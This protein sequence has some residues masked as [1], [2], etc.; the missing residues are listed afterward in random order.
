MGS[1]F[2]MSAFADLSPHPRDEQLE[3]TRIHDADPYDKKVNLTVEEYQDKNG[4]PWVL[5]V[6]RQV[7]INLKSRTNKRTDQNLQTE[8]ELIMDSSLTHK[9]LA[10]PGH[11]GFIKAAQ[12]M[13]FG[14]PSPELRNRLAS[15]QTVSGTAAC[16]LGAR[17]LCGA[18]KPSTVWMSDP[19]C[20]SHQGVWDLVSGIQRRA[21]P[22]GLPDRSGIDF[23]RMMFV[24]STQARRNDIILLHACAHNTTGLD[25]APEQWIEL[26]DLCQRKGIFPFF[27]SAYQGFASGNPDA[28]AWPIRCFVQLG[29]EICVAQS[30]SHNFGLYG[31]RVG[32]LHTVLASSEHREIVV[33]RLCY[34][35]RGLTSTPATYGANIVSMIL[36]SE[37]LYRSWRL[38][39]KKM[40]DRVE[41][42]RLGLYHELM[43]R[44]VPGDWEYLL[45]QV[46]SDINQNVQLLNQR[47][48]IERYVCSH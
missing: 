13:L 37:D 5:P 33:D 38:D 25:P 3:L 16:Q 19:I 22:Y 48:H 42:L 30:F 32:C 28:D 20:A 9:K 36:T 7:N 23:D 2:P 40:T 41:K 15:I 17:F 21:Y 6:V 18:S 27:D 31:E 24:L 8:L 14:N 12:D 26:G 35:Q 39:L 44:R 46:R 34:Y 11:E 29:L 45:L 1:F 47:L 4:E 10:M 43:K